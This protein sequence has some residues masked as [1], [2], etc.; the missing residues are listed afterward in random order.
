MIDL[1]VLALPNGLSIEPSL[2][3]AGQPDGAGY[4]RAYAN[5][6]RHVVNLRP[7]AETPSFDSRAAAEAC[8]LNYL[9]IPIAGIGDLNRAN[10]EVL[11]GW[12]AGVAPATV[13][14]H[15]GSGARVCALLALRAHWLYGATAEQALAI[16]ARAGTTPLLG[17][18]RQLMGG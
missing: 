15:C 5:G 3:S 13:L 1:E 16:A 10:V 17:A 12:I 8:G 4:A 11:D 9:S 18:L 14:V 7:A 2:V 6:I